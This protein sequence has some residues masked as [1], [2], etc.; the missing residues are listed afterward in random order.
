MTRLTKTTPPI[1]TR[2]A[3]LTR[4]TMITIIP[5]ATITTIIT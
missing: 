3:I 2:I 1:T 4:I 5:R